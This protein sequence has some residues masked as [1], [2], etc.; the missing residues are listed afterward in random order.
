MGSVAIAA[1]FMGVLGILLAVMLAIASKR[2]F[3]YEDPRIDEVENLLPKSN[4]GA[5]GTAGC[6][7][8]AEKVVAGEILPAQCTVN[9][10]PQNQ[11]IA[12]LLGVA[13]GKVE[14]RVARLACGGGRHV[15]FMRAHYAGLKSCRAADAVGGG[16]KECAWGC[17][18]LG[19]CEVVCNFKAITL[20]R[21][22]LPVVD[23][24]LCT[25]C[26]DCVDVCPKHLFSLHAVSHKL[27]IACK[28]H[29]DGD[30]AEVSCEVACTACGKC[31]V[32]A[33]PEL[34]RLDN[35]L[36]VIDYDRND[37]AAKDAINRC[38]TGAIV[39]FVDPNRAIKGVSAKKIL[40]QNA[41]PGPEAA[42][43]I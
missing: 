38:P 41:L 10:P 1:G 23:A 11:V 21:H 4:C 18:G 6:R 17:L 31:T 9:A 25:A 36:A 15:A 16:G 34:I 28:N 26:G 13:A 42:T 39:W 8:F 32:D 24:D 37:S 43:S 30:L 14:K 12:D 5:C 29:A 33:A 3:V 2:F 35:N 7:N 22:G 20:N 27:W 40:R 19:D